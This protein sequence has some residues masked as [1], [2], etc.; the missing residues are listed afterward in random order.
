MKNESNGIDLLCSFSSFEIHPDI[1][2]NDDIDTLCPCSS[3]ELLQLFHAP[4]C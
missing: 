1:I 2:D 3:Y 4:K